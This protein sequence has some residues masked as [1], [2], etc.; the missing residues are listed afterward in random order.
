MIETKLADMADAFAAQIRDTEIYRE[1]IL[2]K[3][4]LK[5][6]PDLFA[7]V[8]DYRKKNYIM[9]TESSQDDLFEKLDAFEREYESF[10]EDPMVD[11]FLRAELAF[12][13]MIQEI[14]IRITAGLDFE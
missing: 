2:Q 13:R 1:Y 6:Q 4:R 9:Q 5:K 10:R 3:E 7:Q 8:A 11:D 14:S 12:C